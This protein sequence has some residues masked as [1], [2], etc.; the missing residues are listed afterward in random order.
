MLLGTSRACGY[1]I[2]LLS[3]NAIFLMESDWNIQVDEQTAAR[4]SRPGNPNEV[5]VYRLVTPNSI[6]T[7]IDDTASD[8]LVLA[9]LVLRDHLRSRPDKERRAVAKA[10]ALTKRKHAITSFN[11]RAVKRQMYCEQ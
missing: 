10:T 4:G 6:E 2:N 8:K 9:R 1:G 5:V 3:I 7:A 11:E